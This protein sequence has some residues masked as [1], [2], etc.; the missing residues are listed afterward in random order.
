M[1]ERRIHIEPAP[2]RLLISEPSLT[3]F[4]FKQS[5]VLLAEHNEEGSFGLIVNKPIQAKLNEVTKDFPDFNAQMYL[6]GPVK[7][8]S[9]FYIHT[10]G[11]VIENSI[12]IMDGLYWGGDIHRIK[13]M[14]ILRQL[15]SSEIRFFI[16]YAGWESHQLDRELKE[17]SWVVSTTRAEQVIHTNPRVMW[18]DLMRSF[19]DDYAVWANFPPDLS[20]N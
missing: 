13:E 17:K 16:G 6:G 1:S 3:D 2:G 15:N 10:L 8:D 11:N 7:T 19:G 9:I 5:V 14:M 12:R 4:Y 20:M 18:S